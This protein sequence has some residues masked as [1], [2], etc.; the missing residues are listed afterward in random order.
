V[1]RI[2][3]LGEWIR[4]YQT[5]TS[6]LYGNASALQNKAASSMPCS[7]YAAANFLPYWIAVK[8]QEA[9]GAQA[10]NGIL[11]NHEEPVWDEIYVIHKFIRA[12]ASFETGF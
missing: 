3:G 9:R 1:V 5:A 10:S 12:V 2:L 6:E 7:P 11:F 4:F 8:N